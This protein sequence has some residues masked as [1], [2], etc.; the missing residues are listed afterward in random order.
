MQAFFARVDLA[1]YRQQQ[2]TT[3]KYLTEHP[4]PR[5]VTPPPPRGVGRPK[6]K[7]P[8]AETLAAAGD[9]ADLAATQKNKRVRG[10]VRW[11]NSPYI[12][13]I[14]H[15]HALQGGSARRTVE[16]LR[17]NAADDRY[18]NL[19]HVTVHGWFENGKLKPRH[20]REL[21]DGYA[22]PNNA[23]GASSPLDAAAGASDTICDHLLQLRKAGMPLNSHVVR[24][25]M[26]AVLK[27]HAAVTQQLS[28]SQQFISKWVR[29]NPRLQFRWRARTTAASKLPDDWQEQGISMAQRM[30]ATMQL[31]KVRIHMEYAQL[32]YSCRIPY[33]F[34]VVL[35]RF[36]H[37]LWS[38]WI[39]QV[40]TWCLHRRG[41]M[42]W[43]EAAM[44]P[45][46]ERRTNDR[47]QRVWRRRCAVICFLCN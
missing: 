39:R 43:W 13:D 35:L 8:I 37:L 47:S 28:L 34:L 23:V 19:S 33:L 1:A 9:A 41:H 32:P 5:A 46:W 31:H 4:P 2:Q 15:A 10:H 40:C 44:L 12:T 3:A 17:A 6:K 20:Q 26:Q 42:R 18:A 27:D 30:G 14:L 11:F 25:V 24:W 36:I 21:E 45:L 16:Y 22:H 29:S 38:T 7:R